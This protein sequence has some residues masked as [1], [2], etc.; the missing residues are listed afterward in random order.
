ME[1]PAASRR[2]PRI[3][4]DDKLEAARIDLP[5]SME[6]HGLLYVSIAGSEDS[7]HLFWPNGLEIL[8][9]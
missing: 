3:F 1:C 6:F 7:L 9:H 8:W 5:T 4:A 2:G